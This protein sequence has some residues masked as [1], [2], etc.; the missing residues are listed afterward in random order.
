MTVNLNIWGQWEPEEWFLGEIGVVFCIDSLRELS[1]SGVHLLPDDPKI[2]NPEKYHGQTQLEMLDVS[3]LC[4]DTQALCNMLSFPKALLHVR[5]YQV[6]DEGYEDMPG[7]CAT[8][9]GL[10]AALDKQKHSLEVL[11]IQRPLKIIGSPPIEECTLD[12]SGF[13]KLEEYIGPYRDSS[14]I[15]K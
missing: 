3:G 6:N 12:L 4:I 14:G 9:E 15:S 2:D 1:I 7:E 5:I 8:M 13:P 11:E 10:T